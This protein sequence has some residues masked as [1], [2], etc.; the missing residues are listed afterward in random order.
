[1][2]IDQ[3]KSFYWK[4]KTLDNFVSYIKSPKG[5]VVEQTGNERKKNIMTFLLGFWNKAASGNWYG[6]DYTTGTVAIDN[7]GNV[8]G[9]GTTFT[10]AMVGQ[11]LKATRH[12]KWY[13]VKTYTGATVIVI[14]NDSDDET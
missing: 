1:L 2:V 7:A 10:S 4:E 6:T 14:A 5:T 9:T 8:T 12:T 13:R 3:Y 11:P